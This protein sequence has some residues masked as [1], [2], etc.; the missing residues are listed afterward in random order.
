M[1]FGFNMPSKCPYCF[2]LDSISH[3]FLECEFAYNIW[4]QV[5]KGFNIEI[6]LEGDTFDLMKTCWNPTSLSPAAK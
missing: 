3:F 6:S 5:L 4:K 2:S 1:S